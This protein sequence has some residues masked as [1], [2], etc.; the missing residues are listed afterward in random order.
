MSKVCVSLAIISVLA[1]GGCQTTNNSWSD[2]EGIPYKEALLEWQPVKQTDLYARKISYNGDYQ[3]QWD[4]DKGQIFISKAGHARYSHAEINPKKFGEQMTGWKIFET[5]GAQM[6]AVEIKETRNKYGKFYYAD[7]KTDDGEDCIGF[8]Q[9]LK[10]FAPAGYEDNGKPDGFL[11]GYDCGAHRYTATEIL[12]F[13][14][15]VIYRK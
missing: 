2:W 14:N 12:E 9:A 5:S 7:L 13:S 1:L 8:M 15:N 3:E 4:W 6:T 10:E 11:M